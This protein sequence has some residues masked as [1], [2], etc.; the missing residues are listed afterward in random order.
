MGGSVKK[1]IYSVAV[2]V[3]IIISGSAETGLSAPVKTG[4][5]V[6]V[7]KQQNL[8][9]GKRVGLVTNRT[10][11]DEQFVSSIDLVRGVPGAKLVALYAPEHGIRGGLR[12]NVGNDTDV[13]TGLPVYSLFGST[14][15]PTDEMLDGLDVLLFDMQDIGARSYT[16][17][18]TMRYCMEECAKRHVR[19]IVLDRPNPIN[20]LL[21]DGPVLEPGFESFIG[22]APIPYVHGMTIGELANYFNKELKIN[23][24]LVVVPMDGWQR[25]MSWSDTGLPWVPPSPNIPEPDTPWFYPATG[26]FGELPLVNVGVGYTAPFKIV[27]APWMDGEKVA[28]ILNSRHIPGV[29]FF[30]FSFT[31][32]YGIFKDAYCSGF[33]IMITD[34]KAYRPVEV[35]CHIMEV[36]F[37][38]YPARCSFSLPEVKEDR[39]KMFDRANGT[40]RIRQMLENGSPATKIIESWLPELNMFMKKREKY[41]IY[42]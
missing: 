23:C 18:S 35:G 31:P 40:D 4:I 5:R 30:P 28:G 36:L 41:L 11:I 17:I 29:Y 33:K 32:H 42:Q 8:I 20:G 34:S 25:W 14:R 26:I 12:D 21:V 37:R 2:L 9:S 10:G 13:Q 1:T 3:L 39:I 22:C 19:F 7:E 24:D 27:G 6:L 38:M 15:K 16:Y